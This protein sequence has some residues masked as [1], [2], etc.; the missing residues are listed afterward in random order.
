M[1]GWIQDYAIA[2]A[3]EEFQ[4]RGYERVYTTGGPVQGLS[5]YVDDRSTAASLGAKRLINAGLPPALVQMVP[6]R[7]VQHDRTYH[8]ALALKEWL[9]VHDPAVTGIN[10]VTEGAHARRTRLIFQKVFG[11]NVEIGVISVNSPG[12]D[13]KHWWRYSEGVRSVLGEGIAYL[14]ARLFFTPDSH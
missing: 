12:F 7:V 4:S 11:G 3:L 13:Q 14:Y 5:G 8:A 2:V 1:E 9:R 10:V 6:S